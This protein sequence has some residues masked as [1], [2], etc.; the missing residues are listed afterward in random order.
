MD[1]PHALFLA[2]RTYGTWLHGDARGWVNERRNWRGEPMNRADHRLEA[3]AK[4]LMRAEPT[5]FDDTMR[6]TVDAAIRETAAELALPVMTVRT[7]HVHLVLG[8]EGWDERLLMTF[9]KEATKSLRRSGL[10]PSEGSVWSRGG[11]KRVLAGDDA[12]ESAIDYV[13]HRQ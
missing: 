12:I 7:N 1:Q 5:L 3:A 13:L 11:S 9:K 10:V 4:G 6:K 2:W 8:G